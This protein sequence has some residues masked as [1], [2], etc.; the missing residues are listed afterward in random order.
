M[1]NPKKKRR[2]IFCHV[3]EYSAIVYRTGEL[4]E[5]H[6]H[7]SGS[8]M[9]VQISSLLLATINPPSTKTISKVKVPNVLATTCVLPTAAIKRKRERAI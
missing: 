7:K 8:T 5:E 6:N 1:N 2:N 4:K 9:K 3:K